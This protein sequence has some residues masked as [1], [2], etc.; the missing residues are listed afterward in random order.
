MISVLV[1]RW[2]SSTYLILQRSSARDFGAGEW[3][4]VSGRLEQGEGFVQ[5]IER[6]VREELSFEVRIECMLGTTHFYRGENRPENEIVGVVF[7]CSTSD[8]TVPRLS[9]EHSE[10]RW[11]T[12][13]EAKALLPQEHW[14]GGLIVRAE[15]VREL[16]PRKL[17]QLHWKGDFNF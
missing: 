2:N 3:E 17:R 5:A 9:P 11:V 1:W 12:P 14:L 7:G 4:C 13:E 10:Y 16:L 15:K 6:E 8:S